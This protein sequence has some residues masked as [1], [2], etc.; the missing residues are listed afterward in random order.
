MRKVSSPPANAPSPTRTSGCCES[1]GGC[2]RSSSTQSAQTRR[3]GR[4]APILSREPPPPSVSP[5]RSSL[6]I[7]P[8]AFLPVGKSL[9]GNLGRSILQLSKSTGCDSVYCALSDPE[10]WH[11]EKL[12]SGKILPHSLNGWLAVISRDRR[13]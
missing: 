12:C 3:S 10:R 6:T 9:K 5:P 7:L 1:G 11:H 8:K 4:M 2:Q 13:S